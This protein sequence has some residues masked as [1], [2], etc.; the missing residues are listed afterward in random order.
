VGLALFL[1]AAGLLT[2]AVAAQ[3][4]ASATPRSGNGTLTVSVPEGVFIKA[5]VYVDGKLLA[6]PPDEDREG[7]HYQRN[8]CDGWEL[9][10]GNGLT[11]TTHL[12]KYENLAS[13]VKNASANGKSLFSAREVSVP[14]GKYTVEAAFLWHGTRCDQMRQVPAGFFPFVFS[15]KYTA[16][17]IPGRKTEI[18]IAPPDGYDLGSLTK[19]SPALRAAGCSLVK[20]GQPSEDSLAALE[21]S[22][23]K[24]EHDPQVVALLQAARSHAA[25]P[26]N[27][28]ELDLPADLGGRREFDGAQLNYIVDFFVSGDPMWWAMPGHE[29]VATCR[30][31]YPQFAK[32]FATWDKLIDYVGVQAESIRKLQTS[33]NGNRQTADEPADEQ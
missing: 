1:V 3:S 7:I 16:T 21:S 13:Y 24:F 18:Y 33:L 30:Q 27:V 10:D 32:T 22:I 25:K 19:A 17:V 2:V 6:S 15:A 31:K 20:G 11:L 14:A 23:E 9:S 5:W 4:G 8:K 12:G 29:E 26:G 28:V